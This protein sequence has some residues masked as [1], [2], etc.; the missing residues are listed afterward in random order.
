MSD[1]R[2]LLKEAWSARMA[3]REIKNSNSGRCECSVSHA[4]DRLVLFISVSPGDLF[5]HLLIHLCCA[6]PLPLIYERSIGGLG[7]ERR[8]DIH[9]SYMRSLV[10]AMKGSFEMGR[11]ADGTQLN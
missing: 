3:E 2:C 11:W 6:G 5:P 9:H 1:R 7:R 4:V 10:I 8:L